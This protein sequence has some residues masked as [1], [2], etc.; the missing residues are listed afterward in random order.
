VVYDVSERDRVWLVNVSGV[1][2]IRLGLTEDSPDD[3]ELYNFDIRYQ[4]ARSATGLNWQRLF[5]ARGV[6]LLSLTYSGART[7]Q[8]VKD[9]VREGV[10]DPDVPV[11]DVI[12]GSPVVFE[13]DSREGETTVKYDLTL[14]VPMF[15]KLQ[16]G[17]SFKIF[18]VRYDSAAP[19]GT[20]N[21]YSASPEQNAFD[22]SESFRTYQTGAYLQATKDVTSRLGVTLGA[23]L[24][25]FRYVDRL[26]VSPRAA[27]SYRVSNRLSLRSAYGQYFQQPFLLF[28][29]VFPEN[30]N[31]QPWR[32]DHYVAG[33]AWEP[34]DGWRVTLEGY[35]KNYR[36]YPVAVE[37]PSLSLANVADTFN[38]REI[39]FPLTNEGRGQ[40]TGMELF[41][42]RRSAQ[43]LY[44]QAN[45]ALSRTRHAGGD[46]VLRPGSFDYP[47]VANIV[48]G[49]R[50]S[51]RWEFSTRVSY[52]SGRPYTPYDPVVSSEQRRGVYDLSRVNA[53]RAP[54]YFRFDVRVDRTFRV[55]GDPF[56]L[57]AGVQNL[58]NRRN[59]ANY[60]WNRKSNTLEFSE[61]QGLFPILGFE[62]RF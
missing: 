62:W 28:V 49:Y 4:G 20:D 29:S 42:E 12:A 53:E 34:S 59:F 32:S 17:G 44:G 33:A 3:S 30:R 7:E 22:L 57:F 13:D 26:H 27:I 51:P 55:S 41:I 8:Q 58:T 18:N 56:V 2:E 46:G 25:D 48:G 5:G 43:G 37:Y 60:N 11:D 54:D 9:L 19:L 36:S 24:D 40:S 45:L 35:R 38:V 15:Q 61:Q 6:G 16:V 52:L 10:P 47:V 23:R 31:L 39:L 21:P 1:D 14:N 50:L